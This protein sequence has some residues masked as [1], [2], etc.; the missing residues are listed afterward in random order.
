MAAGPSSPDVMYPPRREPPN[1]DTCAFPD[2]DG[3]VSVYGSNAPV[4][5]KPEPLPPVG[6]VF[7]F[8]VCGQKSE[9]PVFEKPDAGL[10]EI[11]SRMKGEVVRVTDFKGNWVRLA[12]ET[13]AQVE[14]NWEGWMISE[15][16]EE[17]LLEEIEDPT[18]HEVEFTKDLFKRLW[19]ITDHVTLRIRDRTERS[20]QYLRRGR[21]PPGK[22]ALLPEGTRCVNAFWGLEARFVKLAEGEEYWPQGCLALSP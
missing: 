2:G 16:G 12:V 7:F 11:D 8:R 1:Q 4:F 20:L 13:E 6:A 19:S 10:E 9:Q 15:D 17:T 18:E 21:V 14:E 5:K 22:K 3:W